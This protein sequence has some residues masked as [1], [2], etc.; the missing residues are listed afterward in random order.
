MGVVVLEGALIC[1]AMALGL[2]RALLDAV[3]YQLKLGI[4]AGIGAFISWSGAEDR[5]QIPRPTGQPP[6]GGQTNWVLCGD[7]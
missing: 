5:P 2:R 1:V 7:G 6:I 4:G 3:P